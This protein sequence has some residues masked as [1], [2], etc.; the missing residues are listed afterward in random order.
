M[1]LMVRYYRVSTS[2]VALSLVREYMSEQT[3]SINGTVYDKRTGMPVRVE[4]EVHNVTR[5]NAQT[6]HQQPQKSRT[7]NRKYVQRDDAQVV[8]ATPAGLAERTISTHRVIQAPQVSR[9]ESVSRFAK[10]FNRAHAVPQKTIRDIGPTAHPMVR[11]TEAA[12]AAKA[13]VPT[14]V[15]PSSILKTE[16]ISRAMAQ[17][18]A[19]HGGKQVKQKNTSKSHRALSLASAS[20]AIVLLGGYF[21]YLSMP[22]ISTRVAAAQAGIAASYP[23]YHPTGYTLSGPVAFDQGSVSMKF[24]AN[25]GPQAFTLSQTRSGWDSSAVLDNY[26]T[27]KAGENYSATTMNGLTIYTYNSNAAWVNGGILY[28]I[29]GNAPLSGEQIGRIATSL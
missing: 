9:S 25:A 11:R 27:P 21:T 14:V 22:Q 17:T 7:L 19:K 8:A 29:T 6:V 28:T 2:G 10:E 5:H 24:A 18:P 4:R 12:V 13:P 20:L 26:V 3:V 15:K 1:V 16:A 23:G